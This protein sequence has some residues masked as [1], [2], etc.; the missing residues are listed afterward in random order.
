LLWE[1]CAGHRLYKGGDPDSLD[2]AKLAAI[3]PLPARGL[4]NQEHLDAIVARALAFDPAVRYQSARELRVELESYARGASLMASQLRFGAFLGQHFGEELAAL[5]N[6]RERAA[7]EAAVFW[8]R[9]RVAAA[10]SERRTP[11]PSTAKPAFVGPAAFELS[12]DVESAVAQ[13]KP[14]RALF[15]ALSVAL[16]LALIL[17]LALR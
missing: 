10:A 6:E 13:S 8:D 15:A 11:P 9:P 16:G 7:D 2:L 4:P 1:L 14:L 3:P 5:H 17:W 12:D